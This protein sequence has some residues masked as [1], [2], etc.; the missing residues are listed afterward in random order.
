M[1]HKTSHT[2]I[3]VPDAQ[4]VHVYVHVSTNTQLMSKHSTVATERIGVAQFISMTSHHL[5]K[6]VVVDSVVFL[7][8]HVAETDSL[9]HSDVRCAYNHL[10]G[11]SD[12]TTRQAHFNENVHKRLREAQDIRR[13]ATIDAI[14]CS[15]NFSLNLESELI[16]CLCFLAKSLRLS[17]KRA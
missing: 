7:Q 6:Q 15:L 4:H 17:W 1:T 16:W 12:N 8:R 11:H 14:D 10:V 5:I 13:V 2:N 3:H 9:G